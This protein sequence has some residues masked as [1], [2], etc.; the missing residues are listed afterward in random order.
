MPGERRVD[1]V[2]DAGGQ[3]AD[4]GHLLRDLQL[5]LEVHAIGDVLDEQDR[6]GRMSGAG[7]A[8]QRDG[9]RVD[10]QLRRPHR[11]AVV[12]AERLRQRNA[13]ER[14]AVRIL[15]PGRAKRV[16]ER[17]IEHIAAAAGQSR[18]IRGTP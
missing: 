7:L 8:L 17:P 10:Q 15:P 4:R 6:A 16:D 1:L 3:E 12:E 18:P 11:R 14:R 5:L 2:R 9:R 13:V